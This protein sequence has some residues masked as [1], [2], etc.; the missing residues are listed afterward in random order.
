MLIKELQDTC[1]HAHQVHHRRAAQDH[2]EGQQHPR[3]I[4]RREC[5]DPQE[6]KGDILMPSC[7]HI[8]LH[9]MPLAICCIIIVPFNASCHLLSA[10]PKHGAEGRGSHHHEGERRPKKLDVDERSTAG[11]HCSSYTPKG[12]S[13]VVA[14]V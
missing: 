2:A 1:K 5:E 8:H 13:K 14:D 10:G 11:E 7:P 4:R 3:Q 12:Q 9:T 6:A